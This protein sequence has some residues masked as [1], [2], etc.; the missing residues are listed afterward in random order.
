MRKLM[1]VAVAVLGLIST[2]G[3]SAGNL[4]SKPSLGEMTSSAGYKPVMLKCG[5]MVMKRESENQSSPAIRKA[6]P[7]TAGSALLSRR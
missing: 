4:W 6:A 7:A 1:F 3:A 2:S 5:K